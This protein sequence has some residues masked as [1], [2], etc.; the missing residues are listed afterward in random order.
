MV[1]I[2]L[3]GAVLV[4]L[5]RDPHD[6][7]FPLSTYPMFASPRPTTQTLDYAL[8][9]TASGERRV[10]APSLVGTGEVLE[11]LAI[12]GRAIRHGRR[13]S[14]T[15]CSE[16]AGRVARDDRYGDVVTVRLVTG[17]HDALALLRDGTLGREGEHVRCA[18]VR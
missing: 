10:L 9:E 12:V 3:V 5:A 7:G 4:P 11:A 16:I 14:S 13:E 18:V 8:G 1:S 2:V 15:L 17:T 6:D